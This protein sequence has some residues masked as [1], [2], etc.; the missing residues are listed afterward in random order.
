MTAVAVHH[1]YKSYAGKTAVKDLTFSVDPGEILGLIGPNGAGKSST[2]KIIL[3]FMKPDSGEVEV[4]GH[5]M[6]EAS[7]NHIGYLPEEKGLYKNIAAIDLILYLASL[8]GMDNAPAEKKA[9]VLLQQTGMLESKKKKIKHMSKGM[10]QIIQFIVTIIHDPK[11]IILDEPFSGLD[12]VNTDIMKNMIGNL[13]DEGK[14]IILSTHEMNKV[15]ELCNRVL[16][17]DHGGEVLYGDL[18]DIKSKFKKH[19]VQVNVE[20]EIGELPGVI[21]RKL[22]KGSVELVLAPDTTPQIILDQLRDRGL[23]IN[24]FEITTPSLNDI[25]L[26]IVGANHE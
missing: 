13:R 15:E 7:K 23:S 18:K 10:G 2:I 4:F 14:A 19:S 11:L 1:L 9:D 8:K 24:R 6:N 21:D 3:D 22:D 26:N 5:Q 16:M 20:G 12:P 17:I 25:F